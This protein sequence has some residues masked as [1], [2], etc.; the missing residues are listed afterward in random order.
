MIPGA[1]GWCT[2]MTQ[3]DGM[4]REVGEGFRMGNTCT[5]VADSCQCMAKPIQYCKVISLQKK[6]K[7]IAG[8]NINN[9]KYADDITVMAESEEELKSLLMKVKE[10]SEKLA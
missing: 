8:R 3:R 5:P 4:G 7:K 9:L 10:E 2:G 6:K 1:R